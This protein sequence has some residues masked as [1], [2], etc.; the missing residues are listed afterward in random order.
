M[1]NRSPHSN[2]ESTV[3]LLCWDAEVGAPEIYKVPSR[4]RGQVRGKTDAE[5]REGVL[6]SDIVISDY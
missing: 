3:C 1:S 6:Y 2:A 5:I 4:I